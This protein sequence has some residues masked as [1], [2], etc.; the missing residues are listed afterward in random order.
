MINNFE[1]NIEM[2]ANDIDLFAMRL[3]GIS[4][5][6]VSNI[7]IKNCFRKCKFNFEKLTTN[8]EMSFEENDDDFWADLSNLTNIEF[9]NFNSY[10]EVDDFECTEVESNLND[11]QIIQEVYG[12][13]TDVELNE[14]SEHES[15]VISNITRSQAL[16]DINNLQKYFCQIGDNSFDIYF[17]Q[18]QR[19]ITENTFKCLKQT[20][21]NDYFN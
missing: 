20:K 3:I 16:N 18:M 11:E 21:I 2:K 10:I 9:P 15:Q 4:W 1:N 13:A 19:K 17:N 6:N 7:T 12:V 5:K 8:I 14:D